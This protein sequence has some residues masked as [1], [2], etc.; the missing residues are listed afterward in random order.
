MGK[1]DEY[2]SE[3]VIVDF[4]NGTIKVKDVEFQFPK[5]DAQALKIFEAGGLVEYTKKRLKEK[6]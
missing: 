3:E 6:G 5:L 4:D 2:E 1:K